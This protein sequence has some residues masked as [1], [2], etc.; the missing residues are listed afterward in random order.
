MITFRKPRIGLL[1]M[2]IEGYE[3]LFPGIIARQEKYAEELAE[4]LSEIADVSFPGAA[5]TRE[6][7]EKTVKEFNAQGLDGILIVLLAYSH[8]TW[9][10]HAL[11]NNQL[12][13]ALAVL[14]PDEVMLPDYTELDFTVNQGIHGAQ[15]NANAIFRLNKSCQFFAGSRH[16]ERFLAFFR[17]L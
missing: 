11:Q 3:P 6:G 4:S 8:S 13:L 14:Q 15:D 12:P 17:K 9:L 5:V 16:S 10:M 7:V 1:G 2:M